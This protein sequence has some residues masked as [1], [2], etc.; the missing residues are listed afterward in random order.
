MTNNR[1]LPSPVLPGCVAIITETGSFYYS[2]CY[3]A[4]NIKTTADKEVLEWHID[5]MG[6]TTCLRR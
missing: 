3:N 4:T 5:N 1:K 6:D 2:I